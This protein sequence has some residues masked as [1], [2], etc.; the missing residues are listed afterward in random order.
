LKK[1]E[2][3]SKPKPKNSL[4]NYKIIILIEKEK[5]NRKKNIWFALINVADI[6]F[7]SHLE[8]RSH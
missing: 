7:S 1:K 2:H 8:I 6:L 5:K 4:Q 3:K